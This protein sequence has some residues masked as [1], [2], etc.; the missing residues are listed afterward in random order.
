MILYRVGPHL[1]KIYRPPFGRKTPP[2]STLFLILFSP[3]KEAARI[4]VFKGRFQKKN[5]NN[6][7][8]PSDFYQPFYFNISVNFRRLLMPVNSGL[9]FFPLLNKTLKIRR[10]F[11]V[12]LQ[13]VEGC[14]VGQFLDQKENY[15]SVSHH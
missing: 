15:V 6:I 8:N 9:I 2:L 12:K 1:S 11:C 3:H 5:L 10:K 13:Y 7:K 4:F 14:F